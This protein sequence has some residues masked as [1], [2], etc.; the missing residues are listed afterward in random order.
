MK[1][2]VIDLDDTLTVSDIS[3][4][5]ADVEVRPDVAAKLVEYKE[6][7][8]EIV[9]CTARNMRTYEGNI[10]KITV[11]TL[12]IITEWLERH[13]IPFDEIWLG[14]PWCGTDGFYV[15]D[16]AL[17]PDEFVNLD[18]EEVRRLLNMRDE[19]IDQ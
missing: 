17:R 1:R 2:L 6:S 4:H 9:I 7:G 10:G 14:K 5:Y 13:G 3:K 8:F 18:Y 11:H 19:P 15:D 16:K 12:P